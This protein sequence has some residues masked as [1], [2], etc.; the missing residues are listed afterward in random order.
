MAQICGADWRGWHASTY[1]ID[2]AN[3]R[4]A[5]CCLSN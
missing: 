5:G 2:L 4:I 1:S 3:S